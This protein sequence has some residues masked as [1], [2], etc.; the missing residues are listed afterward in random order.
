MS[1]SDDDEHDWLTEMDLEILDVLGSELV[2]SPSII[3]ENIDRSREGV[4]NRLSALNAGGLIKKI[5]RGKYKITPDGLKVTSSKWI[6]VST[7][8]DPG[9]MEIA[10]KADPDEIDSLEDLVGHEM[11]IRR[12]QE[13]ERNI[14]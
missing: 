5:D 2:L 11:S 8:D 10:V 12:K 9:D 13:S 6:Y 4:S 3:A 1:E 7:F 14:D